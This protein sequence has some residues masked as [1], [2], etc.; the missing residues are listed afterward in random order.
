MEAYVIMLNAD[1]DDRLLTQSV[2]DEMQV[3]A[4]IVYLDSISGIKT[5]VEDKGL[6]SVILIN[7]LDHQHT[8]IK[9]I[10]QLKT[11]VLL[12]HVPVVALGEITTTDYIRQYYRAG[13]STY[14]IKPSTIEATKKKIRLFFEYWLGVAEI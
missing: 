8:A 3:A 13:A 10:R 9:T 5:H 4:P 14:I 6:P 1:E 11:D 7:N 2:V 12:N